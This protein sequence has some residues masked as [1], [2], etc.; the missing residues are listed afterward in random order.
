MLVSSD[1]AAPLLQ[2]HSFGSQ[3]LPCSLGCAWSWLCFGPAV[4]IPPQASSQAGE[5]PSLSLGGLFDL[6]V[7]TGM[8]TS[9]FPSSGMRMRGVIHDEEET[10]PILGIK[11]EKEWNRQAA[12]ATATRCTEMIK[13]ST[14]LL[15]CC[16]LLQVSFF[17]P[18]FSFFGHFTCKQ[19]PPSVSQ[20]S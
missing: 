12:P 4:L 15:A 20:S 7:S 3:P 14:C 16:V 19:C 2:L 6:I 11:E 1:T 5:R 10:I 9:I 8:E 13:H 17:S 18:L